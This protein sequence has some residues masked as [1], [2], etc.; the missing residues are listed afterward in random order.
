M[1]PTSAYTV[2]AEVS[3]DTNFT[4]R[5]RRYE[6]SVEIKG[7]RSVC[8]TEPP[9]DCNLLLQQL[10]NNKP[11]FRIQRYLPEVPSKHELR[12]VI[13]YTGDLNSREAKIMEPTTENGISHINP[14]YLSDNEENKPE[15]KTNDF[16]VDIED[17]NVT[18]SS[19][20]PPPMAEV[21]P[22]PESDRSGSK[23]IKIT[24]DSAQSNGTHEP[25]K[26]KEHRK[27][28]G[29]QYFKSRDEEQ[30]WLAWME[31]QF[32]KIAGDDGEISLEEFKDALGV[33]R[34]FFAERFFCLFDTD[35]S[36]SIECG[37]LMD[38][39]RMLTKGTPAQKLKFLFDVYDV[40]GSGSIDRD[41]LK[42]VL[43][44][45][46]EESSLSL[47]EDNLDNLTDVLF[48]AA[49][50]DKS[51]EIAFEE[52][53]AELEKHPGVIENLTI[54]AAQWL[55]PPAASK[56]N[57]KG[58]THRFTWKYI[59]NNL[60]KVIFLVL[61]ILINAALTAYTVYKYRESNAFVIVARI[62][63]MNLNFNCMFI[64]VL[65]LRKCLTYLRATPLANVLPLDQN[66]QFHKM[67]GGMIAFFG[68]IHT[69]AH[70]G[71]ALYT[72]FATPEKNLTTVD[73]LFTTKAGVGWVAA[74]A[75]ITGW[76]IFIILIT[77]VIC[78]L[79][80][81]RRSGHFQVFYW[82]HMLYIPFW[83]LLILHGPIFW[84][85]F[86]AP[87]VIFVFEKI[88]RSKLMK[89]ARYGNTHIT[90]VNLLPS[91]VCHLVISRPDNFVYQPGD[92]I[93]I[94]IPVIAANEWHPFTISS[95]PEMKGH[96]WL[97]VRS[98]G[99][100][101]NMLYEYFSALDPVNL[102][103]GK[104][105]GRKGS[106][107]LEKSQKE[108][109]RE[110]RVSMKNKRV[111]IKCHIDG[112]YGTATRE[113]F[114][115]EHAVLIGAGIGVTPMAS[116]LQSVMYRYKE[117]KRTCPCCQHSFYGPISDH[118]MKLRKVDFI[119]INRDQK[120]FEWFVGILDHI[121]T[122][123]IGVAYDG[124][125][126]PE[127]VIAMHMYMTAAQGKT[128]MKGIGLQIALDLIHQ[129]DNK[130]LITG[131]QT[132]TQAGRPNWNQIFQKIVDEKKG[133]V[134]V[135]FCGAPQLGKMIKNTCMKYKFKFS[136]ENF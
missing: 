76:P 74:S 116:I 106:Q 118:S 128:D 21:S 127:K 86:I 83:I 103:S 65:M 34:S 19:Q 92:Y 73:I 54:S 120:A 41:E 15:I 55:K 69:L 98:A 27:S 110:R 49:D 30:K 8:R 61:Y 130:D 36:G 132:R 67:V 79:P 33:K 12:S 44:S 17:K 115:T 48:D 88:F 136:K 102:A 39:L 58:W 108:F 112:P 91:G 104:I 114:E 111:R 31:V 94:Q 84:M 45:C 11:C 81:V 63:G 16:T 117:S 25:N 97:H 18:T 125:K 5:I 9:N 43:R 89:R 121:E 20:S 133:K 46:M 7:S 72:E 42:T 56:K 77:I 26:E 126:E 100:W 13:S 129:K 105:S 59:R 93:F 75:Y 113:I 80:F 51:G 107:Y 24:I 131:L 122:E 109:E 23:D 2:G 29:I 87:G 52:L 123:Q 14:V 101:T 85:F 4:V 40:D 28:V 96:I 119:W 6:D 134:K 35:K 22:S 32:Q 124:D 78:S 38:G 70:V 135:F 10:S 95:A 82:T 1:I 60:R 90:E 37:E 3:S 64:L 50:E 99:H 57:A 68:I 47:G 62:G 53:K 71:N 66:I